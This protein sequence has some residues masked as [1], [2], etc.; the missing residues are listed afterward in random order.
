MS[1][2]AKN[3][4]GARNLTRRKIARNKTPP[5]PLLRRRRNLTLKGI[6]RSLR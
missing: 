2:R 6:K 4:M 5:P 3:R 1:R